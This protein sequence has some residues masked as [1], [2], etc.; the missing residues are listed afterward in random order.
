MNKEERFNSISHLIAAVA[1]LAGLVLLVVPAAR[2]GD[3]F[4]IVSFSIY[5]TT[6]LL[7][8]TFSALYHSLQGTA[9]KIF[10]KLDHS[11]IYLL[12]AGTYTPFTIVCLR[13]SWGWSLLG[14]IWGL[15]VFGIVEEFFFKKRRRILPIF[16]YLLMGWLILIAL[17]PLLRALPPPGFILLLLGGVFYTG[18]VVFYIFD[19]KVPYFHG[20]WHLFVIAGSLSHYFAVFLYLV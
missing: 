13:G 14:I 16:T 11:S 6:L 17:N 5:G 18:G 8:Y 4:K 9:K 7:L 19:E 10:R 1:S 3:P 15:A 2:Q 12:I 20:I